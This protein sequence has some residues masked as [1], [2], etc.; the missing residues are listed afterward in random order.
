[1]ENEQKADT[2]PG[3]Y[4]VSVIDGQRSARLLGPFV[5]DHQAA[6][7]HVEKVRA[8]AE[9]VD[10]RAVFYAFGTC[11]IPPGDVVPVRAGALNKY[12]GLTTHPQERKS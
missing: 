12:F 8:K 10:P 3:D 4:Y 11:R 2:R 9:E 5:D 6:L 7:D 1:M